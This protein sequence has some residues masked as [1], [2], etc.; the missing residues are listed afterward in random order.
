MQPYFF[1]SLEYM[2]LTTS[3]GVWSDIQ[4]HA[5]SAV[6]PFFCFSWNLKWDVDREKKDEPRPTVVQINY[7]FV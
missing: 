6:V 5:H 4:T 7:L 1:H 2:F 3:E